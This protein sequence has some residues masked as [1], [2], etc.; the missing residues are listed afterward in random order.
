MS[1]IGRCIL[2]YGGSGGDPDPATYCPINNYF[3][4]DDPDSPVIWKPINPA[5]GWFLIAEFQNNSPNS[6]TFDPVITATSGQYAWDFGDGSVAVGDKAVS[7]TYL[8]TATRT[9]KLYGKGTCIIT[10]INISDDNIVGTLDL[11]NSV[12]STMTSWILHT[13]TSMTNVVFP[14]TITGTVSTL[15]LQSTGLSGVVDIQMFTKFT[16]TADIQLHLTPSV[17]GV[18]F[19]S[20]YTGALAFV[21][22]YSSG[23]TGVLDLTR[24]NK[25]STSGNILINS[26]ASMTGVTFASS[27]TGTMAQIAI[28]STG[29][30]G[31]LDL[32]MFTTYNDTGVVT[33]NSN[34]SLTGVTFPASTITGFVRNL[35]L[36]STG[37]TGVVDVSKLKTGLASL[38]WH[39]EGNG[40]S[41][42]VVN[43]ML[44]NLDTMSA[45]GFASR[46]I[47]IGGTNADPDTTSGGYDGV[48]A[49]T[50]LQGKSFTVT[51]T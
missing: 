41:A 14:A 38:A 25:F 20:S 42:A 6:T 43:E 2:P 50:S 35:N 34:P 30:S 39:F 49:R 24:L 33:L 4:P 21:S 27:I 44:V 10:S 29:I 47:N 51:I 3:D 12:F 23:I 18:T 22:L 48:A 7:H 15:Q 8:T 9:V 40:W 37:I 31:V 45:G 28:N 13:N 11:S 32:S 36:Q 5:D 26:N 16:S 19:A 46:V 17:T 1:R